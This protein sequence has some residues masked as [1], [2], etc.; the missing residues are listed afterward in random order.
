[1]RD[2]DATREARRAAE[3][4][5]VLDAIADGLIVFGPRGEVLSMNEAALRYVAGEPR[6]DGQV[7]V[8]A[9]GPSFVEADGTPLTAERSPVARALAG[10]TARGLHLRTLDPETGRRGWVVTSAAPIRGPAG[11][12]DGAVLTFSDETS[13]YRLQEE[14]DDLLR[15][16]THDLRTP[17]NAIYL[18]AHL[19][20]RGTGGAEGASERGRAIVKSCERMSEM[21]QDLADSALLEAGRLQLT[22][23]PIDVAAFAAELLDRLQG[24]LDVDRVRLSVEPGLPPMLAD[25]RRLER[26]LV[27]LVSNA[28]KYSPAQTAVEV[29]AAAI[30]GGVELSVSDHGV[31]ITPEDQ[32][33]LFDR[34]FRARGARRPEG[35]GLGL[36]ITRLLVEAQGGSVR[37]ESAPG[38]G[39]V[40]RVTLP[41]ASDSA[42]GPDRSGG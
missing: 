38:Q 25:P 5:A 18:Q 14:R 42:G 15:A 36:Y 20:E 22:P 33:H 9:R 2:R 1:M 17:L 27:N 16:I 24:G 29:R 3:L 37:V 7:Q 34:W 32:G 11:S 21:I 31:G 19:V 13:V 6:D 8:P 12:V 26:I 30:E 4:E 40:F 41:T 35:L 10:E 23:Q 39:S 28:L